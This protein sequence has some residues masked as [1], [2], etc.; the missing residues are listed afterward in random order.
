MVSRQGFDPVRP[1][2][3][4]DSS[5]IVRGID[6]SA[7][8]QV[9]VDVLLIHDDEQWKLA[10]ATSGGVAS[11]FACDG[12]SCRPVGFEVYVREGDSAEATKSRVRLAL[13][14]PE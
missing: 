6:G 3:S 2:L 9:T 1:E 12:E 11:R 5:A 4:V 8:A 7:D 13:G 14:R 10:A